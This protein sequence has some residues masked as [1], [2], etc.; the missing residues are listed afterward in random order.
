MFDFLGA[1]LLTV[2]C[3]AQRGNNFS[4]SREMRKEKFS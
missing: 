3:A 2:S 1:V 4:V